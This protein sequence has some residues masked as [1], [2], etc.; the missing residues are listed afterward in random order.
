MI[1]VCPI[2]RVL[3]LGAAL[4]GLPYLATAQTPDRVYEH[5]GRLTGAVDQAG[6]VATYQYD[7]VRQSA[8]IQQADGTI[9]GGSLRSASP[10]DNQVT[11]AGVPRPETRRNRSNPVAVPPRAATGSLSVASPDPP[12]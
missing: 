4:R 6:N 2:V 1:R 7:T 5:L 10:S 8:V 9:G 12:R 3:R 11:F